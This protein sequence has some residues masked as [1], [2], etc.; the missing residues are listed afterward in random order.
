MGAAP[1]EASSQSATLPTMLEY[2]SPAASPT[3]NTMPHLSPSI[4][5][6]PISNMTP[7]TAPAAP[8]TTTAA[9]YAASVR[10]GRSS[11][12]TDTRTAQPWSANHYATNSSSYQAPV[13]HP[14]SYAPTQTGSTP[15]SPSSSYPSPPPSAHS[16]PSPPANIPNAGSATHLNAGFHARPPIHH[17]NTAPLPIVQEQQQSSQ[18]SF[19]SAPALP[20]RAPAEAQPQHAHAHPHP[21]HAATMPPPAT[22]SNGYVPTTYAGAGASTSPPVP[23]KNTPYQFQGQAQSPQ[24]P[25]AQSPAATSPISPQGTAVSNGYM[26]VTFHPQGSVPG[27]GANTRPASQSFTN[28]MSVPAPA[29]GLPSQGQAQRPISM[30]GAGMPGRPGANPGGPSRP[31]AATTAATNNNIQN[32]GAGGTAM[33]LIGGLATAAVKGYLKSNGIP[34]GGN[35]GHA[36]QHHQPSI[37]STVISGIHKY[38]QHQQHNQQNHQLQQLQQQQQ[39]LQLQMQ[40]M[41]QMQNGG[42][43]GGGG[44]GDNGNGI[45]DTMNNFMSAMNNGNSSN[46]NGNFNMGDPSNT[47]GNLQDQFNNLT[48]GDPTGGS[49]GGGFGGFLNQ[50]TG[51]GGGGGGDPTNG[52]DLS[53]LTSNL[54]LGGVDMSD[55]FNTSFGG[56]DGF[57]FSDALAQGFAD[58]DAAIF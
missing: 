26:P 31:N 46:S 11:G 8:S 52:F 9:S 1:W 3:D 54:N 57:D 29:Q 4:T 18:P 27:P 13:Y 58:Q 41:Q 35:H 16:Q 30:M 14:D 6:T 44:G 22:Q 5:Q 51:G 10:S 50:F 45:L 12:A 25:Y 38:H 49:G 39:Q 21:H 32:R 42:G 2:P 34:V 40:Q 7:A 28:G 47:F 20:P 17:A 33:N 48:G 56:G 55:T 19:P 15:Y 53:S 43:G 36:Q 24:N 23:P 37:A